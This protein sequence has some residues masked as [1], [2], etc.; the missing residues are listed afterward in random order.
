MSRSIRS[1]QPS[2][3]KGAPVGRPGRTR[4][5]PSRRRSAVT[6]DATGRGQ[7]SI[8]IPRIAKRH[9]SSPKT[10]ISER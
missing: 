4:T 7:C 2:R 3:K 9:G 1:P 5:A 10:T 8:G 6:R